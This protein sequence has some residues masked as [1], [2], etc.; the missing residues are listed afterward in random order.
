ML[1]E[2]GRVVGVV[3]WQINVG[4]NLNMAVPVRHLKALLE[5]HGEQFGD[6]PPSA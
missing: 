1:D 5:A 6:W 2:F 4:Q 3:T